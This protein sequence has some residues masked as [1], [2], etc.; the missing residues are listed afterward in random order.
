MASAPKQIAYG[1]PS[2]ISREDRREELG[3]AAPLPPSVSAIAWTDSEAIVLRGFDMAAIRPGTLFKPE[4]AGRG[5]VRL[6]W[7]AALALSLALHFAAL[8]V[9]ASWSKADRDL[10]APEAVSVEIVADAPSDLPALSL[11][12]APDAAPSRISESALETPPPPSVEPPAA[13]APP[14]PASQSEARSESPP[15]PEEQ[16]L[17]TDQE[18]PAP[19]AVQPPA[20][21]EPPRQPSPLKAAVEETPPSSPPASAPITPKVKP[22]EAQP[23]PISRPATKP[24]PPRDVAPRSIATPP[25]GNREP[26]R[27]APARTTQP[28]Q[29]RSSGAG[30]AASSVDVAAYQSS[31]LNRIAAAKRYPEAAREREL[32]GVAVVRFTISA[33]GQVAGAAVTQSAGDPILD[34]EAVATVRRAS[35][36]PPPPPGAPRTFSASL[37]YRVR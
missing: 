17:P 10:A 24:A 2:S 27:R 4:R 1:R 30:E 35:P 32:R 28:A 23:A 11:P 20:A 18:T 36:F 37:N 8:I 33:S 34:S 3:R 14:A 5:D 9:A 21:D 7:I 16:V 31:V 22:S 15:L 29:E 6:V 12:N 25:R 26:E 13:Q 19:P